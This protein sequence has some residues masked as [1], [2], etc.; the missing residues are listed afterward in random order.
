MKILIAEDDNIS[1]LVLEAKLKN[2]G[3]DVTSV[4]NG[5]RAW[6]EIEKD[7][8]PVLIVDWM[9][10][11]LNGLALCR[12][13]R[14]V[15]RNQYTYVILLTAKEGKAS[16]LEAM[17]AGV[18]DFMTKPCDDEQLVTRIHVA[19]RILGLRQQVTQLEGL[20]PICSFCKKIR[21]EKSSWENLE[22]YVGRFTETRFKHSICEEC[23]TD[24][25]DQP[26]VEELSE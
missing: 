22:G 24:F 16:Y 19:D 23:S 20:L 3:H 11:V 7:Y 13:I 17:K 4:D 12:Q 10:P 21:N 8:F 18:D 14:K 1:R 15:Q 26:P 9:M 5:Q 2:Q 25:L 6:K